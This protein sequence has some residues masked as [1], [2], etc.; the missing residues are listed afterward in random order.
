MGCV[1]KTDLVRVETSLGLSLS[2]RLIEKPV[3]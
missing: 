1:P 3:T 2:K